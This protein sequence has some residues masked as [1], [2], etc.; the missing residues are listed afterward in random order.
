LLAATARKLNTDREYLPKLQIWTW[1]QGVLFVVF[2][3]MVYTI[4]IG[5]FLIIF[6]AVY[7]LSLGLAFGITIRMRETVEAIGVGSAK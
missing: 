6:G 1:V 3:V 2:M 5:L 4:N 7:L